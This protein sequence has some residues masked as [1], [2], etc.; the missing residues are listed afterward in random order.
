ME[1]W[2][3][4]SDKI[5]SIDV[6]YSLSKY[7]SVHETV[8]PQF[9]EVLAFK[10]GHHPTRI[11]MKMKSHPNDC[12]A[13]R[14]SRIQVISGANMSGK[15]VYT[16][17][18]SILVVMCQMGCYVPCELM[19]FPIFESILTRIGN[20][21]DLATNASTFV[22][23]MRSLS[24]IFDKVTP[25]SLVIIDELARG[26]CHIDAIAISLATIERLLNSQAI[27]FMVTHIEELI[28]PL[29]QYPGIIQIHFHSEVRQNGIQY[30]YEIQEGASKSRFYGIDL[31][32]NAALPVELVEDAREMAKDLYEDE[33]NLIYIDSSVNLL[34]I[35]QVFYEMIRNVCSKPNPATLK[36]LKEYQRQYVEALSK[37]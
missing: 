3:T 36:L 6:I 35:Q 16:K 28:E 10:Q 23:E 18:I 26:T 17:Q 12:Y 14:E 21:D 13:S 11:S 1:L 30:Y 31:A 5:A 4:I 32:K 20:D 15:S 33:Q 37:L 22:K 27:T 7:S 25:K 34:K 8:R 9:S 19:Y 2:Y 29:E 24:Y